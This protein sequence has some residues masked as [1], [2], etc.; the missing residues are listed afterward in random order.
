[1]SDQPFAKPLPKHRK[2]QTQNKRTHTP[3]NHT[4]SGIRTHDPSERE[5]R[6]HVLDRAVTVTGWWNICTH[7]YIGL[8]VHTPI[9]SKSSTT[10]IFGIF[11]KINYSEVMK[12]SYHVVNDGFLLCYV[13]QNSEY[14]VK[15]VLF[16]NFRAHVVSAGRP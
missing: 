10:R 14:A 4:L 9:L 16:Y 3:N 8:R 1:V 5:K 15:L 2:T 13:I 11:L 12:F 6:V 7:V